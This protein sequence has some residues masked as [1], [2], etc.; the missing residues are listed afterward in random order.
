[1]RE[2][3]GGVS[4]VPREARPYQGQRAGLVTR[5]LAGTVDILVVAAALAIGYA[6]WIGLRFVLDPRGFDF[7]GLRPLPGVTWALVLLVV[8]LTAAWSVTGRTYGGHVMGL[9]LVDRRGR[10]PGPLAASARAVLC[11]LF[12]IGLVWCVVGPTRRSVQDLL[13]RTVVIYDWLPEAEN[14]GP[15]FPQDTDGGTGRFTPGG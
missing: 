11:A 4:P 3:P 8:Y 12:P 14:G 7:T 13:L 9:R 1:M 2:A 15:P 6:G 10:H 5:T